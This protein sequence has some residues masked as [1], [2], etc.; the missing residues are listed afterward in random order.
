MSI[1]ENSAEIL[2][3]LYLRRN[4]NAGFEQVKGDFELGE[5]EI[6]ESFDYLEGKGYIQM[7]KTLGGVIFQGLTHE[8]IDTV[9]DDERFKKSFTVGLN[10][11]LIKGEYGLEEK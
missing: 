1:Q 2:Q 8:G 6:I 11:G 9:E 3:Y 7:K 10:L 4:E 5:N